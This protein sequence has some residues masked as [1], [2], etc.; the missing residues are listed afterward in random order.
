[1]HVIPTDFR[2]LAKSVMNSGQ[3]G[4]FGCWKAGHSHLEAYQEGSK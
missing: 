2:D 4:H 3:R 1:M